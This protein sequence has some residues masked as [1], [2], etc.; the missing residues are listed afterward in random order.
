MVTLP[1]KTKVSALVAVFTTTGVSVKIGTTTQVSGTT[2]NNFSSSKVYTVTA[3]D[4]STKAYT[5]RVSVA[6]NTYTEKIRTTGSGD[7]WILESSEYSN[8]GG[9]SGYPTS[10]LIKLGDDAQDRQYRG[11]LHFPTFYLPDNAVVTKAVLMIKKK[12]TVG[13]DPFTTHGSITADIKRGLFLSPTSYAINPLPPEIFQATADMYSAG[14]IQNNPSNGWYWTSLD[15]KALRYINLLGGTQMRLQ[16]QLDD[17][18]NLSDDYIN[19]YSGDKVAQG[20]RPYLTIDYYV[21][22]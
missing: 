14:I 7:G 22:R 21:P 17:N 3:A 4:G 15:S 9:F 12:D 5:V 6:P 13:T 2:V 8:L 1:P 19:F 20:D 10:N 11:L 18:D 16:F